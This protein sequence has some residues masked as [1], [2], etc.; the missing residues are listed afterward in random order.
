MS[1]DDKELEQLKKRRLA[2]MEKNIALK[3]RLEEIPISKKTQPSAR[4]ILVKNL[5]YRGLEV[6]Q[7]AESQ[8]PSET[9]I[10]VEKLGELLY[11][12]EISE[13]IDGGKLLALFRSVG[14]NVRMQTKINVEQDG[15]FVSLS[16][17]LTSKS[18]NN[19]TLIEDD[20][21]SQ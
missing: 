5:G 6:L 1:E 18:S 21:D 7:N 19:E 4:E 10:V 16:D 3:Q 17:K 12:G 9:K 13:E 20:L 8:F 2:E 15:E 11:S 14:I